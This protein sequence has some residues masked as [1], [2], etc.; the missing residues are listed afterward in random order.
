MTTTGE[1]LLP[2]EWLKPGAVVPV[3]AESV[4][5]LLDAV[6]GMTA[7]QGNAA[8]APDGVF[9]GRI[10]VDQLTGKRQLNV[11]HNADDLPD[12]TPVYAVAASQEQKG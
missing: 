5:L 3:T 1:V 4:R 9:V 11:N 2:A 12:L 6:Q 8:Q 10:F 7:P